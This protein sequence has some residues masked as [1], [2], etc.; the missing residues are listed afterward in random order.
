MCTLYYT[1]MEHVQLAAHVLLK[2][3]VILLH[4]HLVQHAEP[5]QRHTHTHYEDEVP[6][7]TCIVY[8]VLVL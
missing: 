1:E 7:G 2:E 8:S 5:L 3:S 4:I 6:Y